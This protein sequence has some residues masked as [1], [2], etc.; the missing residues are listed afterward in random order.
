MPTIYSAVEMIDVTY[1][2]GD[3]TYTG[4]P[5]TTPWTPLG[6]YTPLDPADYDGVC[7]FTF[8]IVVYTPPYA[9]LPTPFALVNITT[10]ETMVTL[11]V[12][13]AA[14]GMYFG[15]FVPT[16]GLNVY[17]VTIPPPEND[18]VNLTGQNLVSCR[19]CILQTGATKFVQSVPLTAAYSGHRYYTDAEHYHGHTTSSTYN[20][21]TRNTTGPKTYMA[22]RPN[23]NY[24]RLA[25]AQLLAVAFGPGTIGLMD[26][27]RAT[28]AT[29]FGSAQYATQTP[30]ASLTFTDA[31]PALKTVDLAASV[32]DYTRDC[33][34]P[35]KA[36]S[37]HFY[38]DKA[39]LNLYY[40]NL[41]SD[42][43]FA[44]VGGDGWSP[45]EQF[46]RIPWSGSAL[47]QM[48]G[49][50][51]GARYNLAVLDHEENYTGLIASA[52]T[53]CGDSA[54]N[55]PNTEVAG[56][57]TDLVTS[58]YGTVYRGGAFPVLADHVYALAPPECP[59]PAGLTYTIYSYCYSN[60][61]LLSEADAPTPAA[62]PS[63]C[64][65]DMPIAPGSNL[66]GCP[67]TFFDPL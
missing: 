30:L 22:W 8:E 7:T 28:V 40:T 21:G 58:G 10:G 23:I 4:H 5:V 60:L 26:Y 27:D 25:K 9:T 32:L 50:L 11:D 67:A 3:M 17:A 36:N 35:I 38:L 54:L 46:A 48:A 29:Y 41:S 64:G 63:G 2:N 65:T 43:V 37:G 6:S 55:A 19:I 47:L 20:F 57:R 16:P 51:G 52:T 24:A 61:L 45:V 18:L 49:A 62:G 42:T 33:I 56:S 59:R 31:T 39:R 44:R 53:P 12:D 34:A 15:N 66:S 13:P 1:R 14:D